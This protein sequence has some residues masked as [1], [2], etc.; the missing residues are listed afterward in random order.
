MNVRHGLAAAVP[1]VCL[2]V[3]ACGLL[4]GC[5][6]APFRDAQV[7]PRSPIAVEVAKT[8]RPH[9]AYPTFAAFP[10]APK[11]LRPVRQYGVDAAAV[12]KSGQQL[13]K[14]TAEDTWTITDTEGFAAQAQIDAGPALPPANPADTEAFANAQKARATQPPKAKR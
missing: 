9:A 6:A 1:A 4:S 8:V 2:V 11:G 13:V 5:I 7:D 14:A 3:G 10:A 12:E